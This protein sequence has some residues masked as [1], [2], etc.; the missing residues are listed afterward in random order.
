MMLSAKNKEATPD[1]SID[2][3]LELKKKVEAKLPDAVIVTSAPMKRTDQVG[4]SVICISAPP[5]MQKCP[6]G[7][8]CCTI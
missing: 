1:K 6:G 2:A 5:P 8:K 4:A 7:P 3:L